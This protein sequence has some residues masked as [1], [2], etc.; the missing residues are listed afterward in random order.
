MVGTTASIRS[1]LSLIGH[2]FVCDIGLHLE[3][4][5][6]GVAEG[7]VRGLA[8][9]ISVKVGRS[10]TGD[11]PSVGGLTV[12]VGAPPV[13]SPSSPAIGFTIHAAPSSTTSSPSTATNVTSSPAKTGSSSVPTTPTPSSPKPSGSNGRPKSP[14]PPPPPGGGSSI[15]SPTNGSRG[16]GLP[17][18]KHPSLSKSMSLPKTQMA[19]QLAGGP[20]PPTS[21]GGVNG[22]A[23]SAT[24]PGHRKKPSG[25]MAINWNGPTPVPAPGPAATA[26]AAPVP[27]STARPPPPAKR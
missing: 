21:P 13:K 3:A 25:A 6:D 5:T 17:A 7:W 20:S 15:A 19:Q 12:S 27:A 10:V 9:L 8:A 24:S 26:A 1:S 16:L 18:G 23:E 14:P 22:A 11:A 2:P 4:D